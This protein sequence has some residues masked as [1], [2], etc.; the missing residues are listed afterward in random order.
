MRDV[1]SDGV[2]IRSHQLLNRTLRNE[3]SIG[4]LIS[5]LDNPPDPPGSFCA[6]QWD[7]IRYG[8]IT[9]ELESIMA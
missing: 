3:A 8:D 5:A 1:D 4:D 7:R 6:T 2:T 9:V